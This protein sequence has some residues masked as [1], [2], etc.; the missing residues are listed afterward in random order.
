M[1]SF[2]IDLPFLPPPLALWVWEWRGPK[3]GTCKESK[4]GLQKDAPA[5]CDLAGADPLVL[6]GRRSGHVGGIYPPKPLPSISAQPGFLPIERDFSTDRSRPRGIPRDEA[7][8][9]PRPEPQ[10]DGSR[11]GTM[12]NYG[13]VA[14]ARAI[15]MQ[16]GDCPSIKGTMGIRANRSPQTAWLYEP[17]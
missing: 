8:G 10:L 4:R 13:K 1:Q 2:W 16:A 5:E 14:S 7:R 3:G 17:G 12:A 9:K 11:F 6:R 15:F